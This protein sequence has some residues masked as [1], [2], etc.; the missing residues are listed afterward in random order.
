M[1]PFTVLDH[2]EE[3]FYM[4]F[5]EHPDFMGGNFGGS[6]HIIASRILGLTYP[7]YLRYMRDKFGGEIRGREGY[8]TVI[9]K[10]QGKALIAAQEL[11]KAWQSVEKALS[12]VTLERKDDIAAPVV[13]EVNGKLREL[14]V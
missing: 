9:F 5:F 1:K 14:R 2:Y 12:Q 3:G 10:D 13:K 8:S 4:V 11:N 6:Y 7:N